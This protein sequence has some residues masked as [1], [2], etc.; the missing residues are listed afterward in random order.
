M[1]KNLASLSLIVAVIFLFACNKEKQFSVIPQ[2][3]FQSFALYKDA[4]GKDTTVDFIFTF[5]DGDGDIGTPDNEL[6][7]T[8]GANNDNL[9][10]AYEE[11]KQNNYY[12]KK[13]WIQVETVDKNCDTTLA[14]DSVQ[15]QFNQ[16]MQYVEPAGNKKSIEGTVTYRMDYLSA[17]VLLS[18][19]GRFIFYIKDRAR[20]QSN[21]VTTPEL[22]IVK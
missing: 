19:Q 21:I 4:A 2:I 6:D 7:T 10:I 3:E 20:H 18:A 17:V 13:F 22:N 1:K 16:R 11:K 5:K 14:F 12:P 8:C 9:F 15:V